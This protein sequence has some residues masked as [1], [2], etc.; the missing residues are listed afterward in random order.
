MKL[1][2]LLLLFLLPF[3]VN[4]AITNV[5]D[6]LLIRNNFQFTGGTPGLNKVLT[7]DASGF[8]VPQSILAIQSSLVTNIVSSVPA[9]SITGQ[10]GNTIT[11]NQVGTIITNGAS[12]TF[13]T[14]NATTF[15]G[16]TVTNGSSVFTPTTAQYG[17][18][19]SF[20]ETHVGTTQTYPN[21][22]NYNAGVVTWPVDLTGVA[23]NNVPLVVGGTGGISSI[24]S[25]TNLT[26]NLNV[27]SG[28]GVLNTQARYTTSTNSSSGPVVM[29]LVYTN[30][31]IQ[32]LR[33][34]TGVV[35]PTADATKNVVEFWVMGGGETNKNIVTTYGGV[36]ISPVTQTFGGTVQP[37]DL[38]MWTNTVSTPGASTLN[39]AYTRAVY[40]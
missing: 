26:M 25:G 22:M 37:T 19:S 8:Y 23:S 35:M 28:A 30:N 5:N 38:Y 20:I 24:S 36:A 31:T 4:A 17:F 18:N 33:I 9:I 13:I 10:G 12:P 14:L 39:N 11:L 16:T 34:T 15:T 40:E 29:N 32:R 1:K 2:L 21:G 27:N 6:N 3:V 7:S